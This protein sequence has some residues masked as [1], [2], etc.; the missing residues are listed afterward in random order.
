MSDG[1]VFSFLFGLAHK[2]QLLDW[3]FVFL[4]SY[5]I[6]FLVIVF[7]YFL[8]KEKDWRRRFYF[9]ALAIISV[10]LS[11]GIITDLIR[12]FYNKPRPFA[13]LD[14]NSLI[15]HSATASFPSGHMTFFIPIVLTAWLMNRKA[16]IWLSV[17]AVLIGI[18]RIAVGIHWPSDILGGILIGA[19][20]FFTTYY[21]LRLKGFTLNGRTVSQMQ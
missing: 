16:G 6:I 7:L 19:V 21:L 9:S 5:L 20:S 10:L 4:A 2:N 15:E 18:S 1:S 12:Y 14:I 11:R 17:G 8:F 3:L 13:V